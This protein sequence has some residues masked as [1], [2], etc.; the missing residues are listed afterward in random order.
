MKTR[1]EIK[2]K[3]VLEKVREVVPSGKLFVEYRNNNTTIIFDKQLT[4]TEI[5]RIKDLL[6]DKFNIDVK[7]VED[8]PKMGLA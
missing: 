8:F 5:Q 3:T 4:T 7:E 2:E 1:I 6:G